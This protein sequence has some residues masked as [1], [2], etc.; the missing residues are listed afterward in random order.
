MNAALMCGVFF[1]DDG[2]RANIHKTV[3]LAHAGTH[4]EYA[5]GDAYSLKE[6]PVRE[7][8]HA[9]RLHRKR[10]AASTARGR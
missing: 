1:E 8:G 9:F 6:T 3:V 5:E 10:L 2:V 4:V 7:F